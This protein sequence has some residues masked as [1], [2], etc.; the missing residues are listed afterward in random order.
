MGLKTQNLL[1]ILVIVLVCSITPISAVQ[2]G[3]QTNESDFSNLWITAV[4]QNFTSLNCQETVEITPEQEKYYLNHSDSIIN[5]ES[6]VVN[7]MQLLW[8]EMLKE[9]LNDVQSKISGKTT[10]LKDEYDNSLEDMVNYLNKKNCSVNTTSNNYNDT[11]AYVNKTKNDKNGFIVQFKQ[12]NYIRYMELV[13]IT[14]DEIILTSPGRNENFTKKEMVSKVKNGNINLIIVPSTHHTNNVLSDIY[15]HQY[16]TLY[17]NKQNEDWKILGASLIAT[18]CI[19]VVS[20]G[21]W[22]AISPSERQN[23]VNGGEDEAIDL[24]EQG[25]VDEGTP[26]TD[27]MT[28]ISAKAVAAADGNNTLSAYILNKNENKNIGQCSQIT[29]AVIT[30][31]VTAVIGGTVATIIGTYF[32]HVMDDIEEEIKDLNTYM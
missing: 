12:N 15:Q 3:S 10:P 25:K 31:T 4:Q 6:S 21:L 16:S 32:K 26:L 27:A 11:I 1:I 5:K 29:R 7:T 17:N 30:I 18:F 14:D 28:S 24:M 13:N 19:A 8:V 22:K 20:G 23:A 9:V 2:M